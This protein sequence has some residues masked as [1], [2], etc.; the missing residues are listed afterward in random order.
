MSGQLNILIVQNLTHKRQFHSDQN[1]ALNG[2]KSLP[3]CHKQDIF[4][5]DQVNSSGAGE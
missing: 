4:H 2:L 3:S 1:D 5:T